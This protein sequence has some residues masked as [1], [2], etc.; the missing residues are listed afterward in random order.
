[1]NRLFVG[2]G[3]LALGLVAE[4]RAADWPQ[5]LGPTR[6]AHSPETGLVRPFPKKGPAVLWQKEDGEGYSGPVV[7]G[8]RL[9]LY[10]R[11]GD[12]DVDDYLDPATGK[13]HSK[14]SPE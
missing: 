3:L 2:A 4:V 13:H 1:M 11:V 6:D 7:A 8:R 5:F 9:I 14:H 10:Q 12:D